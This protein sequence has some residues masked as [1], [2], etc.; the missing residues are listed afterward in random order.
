M[1]RYKKGEWSGLYQ[2]ILIMYEQGKSPKEISEYLGMYPTS[3]SRIINRDNFISRRLAFEEKIV[4]KVRAQFETKA[5][6]AAK[7][8]CDLAHT[9][10]P[11]QKIQLEAAKEVLYQIGCKPPEVIE[12]RHREYT[13]EELQSSLNVAREMEA[14]ADTL[15]SVKSPYVIEKKEAVTI[16]KEDAIAN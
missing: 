16:A 13:P 5:L 4:D 11:E 1:A 15:S 3:V 10:K 2:R 9:G 12:T 6:T 8:I 7:K 14:I